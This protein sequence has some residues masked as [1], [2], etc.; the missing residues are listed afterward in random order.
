MPATPRILMVDDNWEILESHRRIMEERFGFEVCTVEK[1]DEIEDII[2]NNDV[3]CIHSDIIF[4]T[5]ARYP[6]WSKPNGL[7]KLG[8]IFRK[9]TG[10]PIMIISAFIDTE[11]IKKA[12]EYGIND[13]IC[14]WY[15]KP[16]DPYLIAFDTIKVINDNW[17]K[18]RNSH[19]IDFDRTLKT[20]VRK[21]Q[22][23]PGLLL[24]KI[25]ELMTDILYGY[26]SEFK[27][28]RLQRL[29]NLIKIHLC[30]YFDER[31]GS[32]LKIARC[33]VS[34]ISMVKDGSFMPTEIIGL[35]MNIFKKLKNESLSVNDIYET[36]RDLEKTLNIM[37][38]SNIANSKSI[39]EV[40]NKIASKLNEE[41][42]I[43]ISYLNENME[44][45]RRLNERLKSEGFEVW[46]DKDQIMPGERW[47]DA[48]RK[49]IRDGAFFIASCHRS[50][51]II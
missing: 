35:L 7:S 43:F 45:V 22:L 15:L 8:D 19:L 18:N 2:E 9:H 17:L 21:I 37:L 39:S 10:I 32:H 6:D 40:R 28:A 49:A 27:S 14:N 23:K 41:R 46:L 47:Q 20:D 50:P 29:H 24:N 42:H 12:K 3:D 34:T 13:L 38:E 51:G 5:A 1:L 25:D 48:I 31:G 30:D 44:D 16:V 36:K 33:I 4:E 26:K 11:T